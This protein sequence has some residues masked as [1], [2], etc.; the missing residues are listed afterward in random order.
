M[1]NSLKGL[2]LAAGTI[3]TCVV[4]TL[5]F[6]I[7]KEARATAANGAKEIN[8]L[9]AEFAESDKTIYD[10]VVVSGSEVINLIKK[11]E[12]EA[13]GICVKTKS[14]MT[15]FGYNFDISTGDLAT[16]SNKTYFDAINETAT[17]YVNPYGNFRGHVIRNANEV[18]TGIIFAQE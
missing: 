18:I 2:M 14:S 11:T 16:K 1:E 15:Y 4:I 9:N 13:L 17:T 5:G 8:K 3:I 6:Y 7:S 10:G 12:D